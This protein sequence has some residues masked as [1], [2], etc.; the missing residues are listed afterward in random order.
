MTPQGNGS[1]SQSQERD[2]AINSEAE[3]K[4]KNRL[5]AQS[6]VPR[7]EYQMMLKTTSLGNRCR[8]LLCQ[9]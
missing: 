7:Q 8:H 9:V 3:K 2:L 4:I 5:Q 1:G 6:V